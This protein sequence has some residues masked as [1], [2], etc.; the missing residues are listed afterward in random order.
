[1]TTEAVAHHVDPPQ[2]PS[3]CE[4]PLPILVH[5]HKRCSV[6]NGGQAHG[7]CPHKEALHGV[8]QHLAQ[9]LA[10]GR[11]SLDLNNVLKTDKSIIISSSASDTPRWKMHL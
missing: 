1:M 7:N 9:H 10:P 11:A 2:R 6:H 4:R 3:Q 5:R 8:G